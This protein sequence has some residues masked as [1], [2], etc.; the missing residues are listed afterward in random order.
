[1]IEAVLKEM[2][3]EK[4]PCHRRHRV[5]CHFIYRRMLVA[6]G[7]VERRTHANIDSRTAMLAMT[8]EAFEVARGAQWQSP[9]CYQSVF[10]S[11]I[12]AAM[13]IAVADIAVTIDASII[14]RTAPRTVAGGAVTAELL[15]SGKQRTWLI[16]RT[17][18]EQQQAN[19]R[20]QNAPGQRAARPIHIP[21]KYSTP[22]TWKTISASTVIARRRCIR[23]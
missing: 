9:A 11:D 16:A 8:T 1:M 14:R 4:L 18:R 23:S 5:L 7:A 15:M 21:A 3:H 17:G 22:A 10:Q 2:A 12:E 19:C 6:P 20:D 13:W